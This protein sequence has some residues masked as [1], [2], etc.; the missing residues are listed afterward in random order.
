MVYLGLSPILLDNFNFLLMNEKL[1]PQQPDYFDSQILQTNSIQTALS[2]LNFNSQINPPTGNGNIENQEIFQPIF[3]PTLPLDLRDLPTNYSSFTEFL[4]ISF[5]QNGLGLPDY[6]K[7]HPKSQESDLD[8]LNGQAPKTAN[9]QNTAINS[10]IDPLTNYNAFLDSENAER[11][12]SKLEKAFIQP[13]LTADQEK[14]VGQILDY[15]PNLKKILP[16]ITLIFTD[17]KPSKEFLLNILPPYNADEIF[18]VIG[19]SKARSSYSLDQEGIY[20]P[21][22]VFNLPEMEKKSK[23]EKSASSLLFNELFDLVLS[24]KLRDSNPTD[25]N[26]YAD[27]FA[28]QVPT[29]FAVLQLLYPNTTIEDAFKNILLSVQPY[30]EPFVGSMSDLNLIKNTVIDVLKV[31]YDKNLPKDL[32]INKNGILLPNLLKEELTQLYSTDTGIEGTGQ[33]DNILVGPDTNQLNARDGNDVVLAFP[34]SEP[35]SYSL[36]K[37][38]N[39]LFLVPSDGKVEAN[40]GR[41]NDELHLSFNKEGSPVDLAIKNFEHIYFPP[42]VPFHKNSKI[43]IS[44]S[45]PGITIKIYNLAKKFREFLIVDKTVL[46]EFFN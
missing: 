34:G 31:F 14:I 39:K 9:E 44:S 4:P 12:A 17:G 27:L 43:T 37:G 38:E 21:F 2:F 19:Q 40:G 16:D 10:Q 36:G 22:M 35:T 33:A 3:Q 46:V 32:I 15:L 11:R 6:P 29:Y 23:L 45:T 25:P 13:N 42:N 30:S 41:N 5:S 8:I 26:L 1:L 18:E 7:S 20:R 24:A 28:S